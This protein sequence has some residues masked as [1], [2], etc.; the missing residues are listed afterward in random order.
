M[1]AGGS[2]KDSLPTAPKDHHRSPNEFLVYVFLLYQSFLNL[3]F[4]WR[5]LFSMEPSME[6]GDQQDGTIMLGR[7]HLSE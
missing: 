3:G 4:E 6:T 7:K 2:T 5:L 1:Q